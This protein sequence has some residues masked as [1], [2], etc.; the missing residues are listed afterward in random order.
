MA[1]PD[2][3]IPRA[4]QKATHHSRAGFVHHLHYGRPSNYEVYRFLGDNLLAVPLCQTG[5]FPLFDRQPAA[6]L[7]AKLFP[8]MTQK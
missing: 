8:P 5:I 4:G 1:S 2:Y 3:G 7:I 6:L